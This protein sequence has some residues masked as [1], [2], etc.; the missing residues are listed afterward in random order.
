MG[1]LRALASKQ[2]FNFHRIQIE[3]QGMQLPQK[4]QY[5]VTRMLSFTLG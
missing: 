2:E 3:V 1:F 4:N 5:S